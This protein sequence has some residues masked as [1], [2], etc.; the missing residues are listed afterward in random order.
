MNHLEAQAL[1][2]AAHDGETVPE[3][4]LAAARAHCYECAECTAFAAGLLALDRVPVTGAPDGLID[5]VLSAIEPL[6]TRRAEEI[7]LQAERD[8]AAGVVLEAFV[9]ADEVEPEWPIP[10]ADAVL[11]PAP[12][13]RFEWFQ[14]PTRWATFGAAGALAA[15]A[16]I[17]FIVVGI[18]GPGSSR[19]ATT[20]G[21]STSPEVSYTDTGQKG[22]PSVT[23]QTPPPAPVQAPDYVLF[24]DFV[25][26]P[27]ALLAD[28]GSATPTI[29]TLTTA[30]ASGG[31][32]TATVY[33]SPL[34]DGSI[35]VKGPDGLRVY[36][37]VVRLLSSVRYQLTSG[38]PI[39]RF[40][41]WPV[42]PSR[43]PVPT[44]TDGAPSFVAAG[45]DAL[46]V[47]IY[48]ATGR[49]VTEGFAV[50]PGTATSDPAGGNPN[51]TWW[52]PAP[53]NP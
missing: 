20:A 19:N 13:S 49:P 23:A 15:T 36:A 17:A 42:L 43:F 11:L 12:P 8:A 10:G 47:N 16:L 7:A 29:G 40:G 32:Q 34:T 35:V 39:E 48:A 38:K 5:R 2:S 53:A 27:G 45:S 30:F 9:P 1:I 52:T 4:E 22:A 26:A 44:N 33:R 6:Q 37:P 51:W 28:A 18:G 46:S 50:A 25:Y 41:V 21:V 14:G 3:P 24:K 31:P